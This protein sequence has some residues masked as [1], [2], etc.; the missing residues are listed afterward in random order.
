MSLTSFSFVNANPPNQEEMESRRYRNCLK[1]NGFGEDRDKSLLD[2]IQHMSG[3]HTSKV[4]YQL[5][6]KE[7]E[8]IEVRY[9]KRKTQ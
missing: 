5:Y 2:S 1:K 8:D 4:Y 6:N 9:L 3:K 7:D